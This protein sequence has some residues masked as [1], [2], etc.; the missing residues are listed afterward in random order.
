M[1]FPGLYYPQLHSI[2]FFPLLFVKS[3]SPLHLPVNHQE[4]QAKHHRIRADM[5]HLT[6]ILNYLQASTSTTYNS[7]QDDS[8]TVPKHPSAGYMMLF[9]ILIIVML[10]FHIHGYRE[11]WRR[12][13]RQ[14]NRLSALEDG[15]MDIRGRLLPKTGCPSLDED[16]DFELPPPAYEVH[17]GFLKD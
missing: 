3:S 8:D 1:H 10:F 17:D 2:F 15:M 12:D 4:P 6:Y 16:D 11:L 5:S 14:Q 9:V 7:S 13:Q